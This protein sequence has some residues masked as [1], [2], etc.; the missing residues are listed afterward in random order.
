MYTIS[1]IG[2]L[3]GRLVLNG[4]VQ[5]SLLN[6][7]ELVVRAEDGPNVICTQTTLVQT[8]GSSP[9]SV[10]Y[11]NIAFRKLTFYA[12]P[13]VDLTHTLVTPEPGSTINI[14]S[15]GIDGGTMTHQVTGCSGG[16]VMIDLSGT[17]PQ[18]V[19]IGQNG[20]LSALA[21]CNVIAH[22]DSSVV[23][24][25]ALVID[26]T[27]DSRTLH[28]VY[29]I[30]SLYVKNPAIPDD[31]FYVQFSDVAQVIVSY[32]NGMT[33]EMGASTQNFQTE[34]L[35]MFP[36]SPTS[37]CSVLI[38]ALPNAMFINGTVTVTANTQVSST[39]PFDNIQGMLV[40][41][42]GVG[43]VKSQVNII[44]TSAFGTIPNFYYADNSCLSILNST[45]GV[46]SP[47]STPS[48]WM[49]DLIQQAGFTD[50]CRNC[51][52]RYIGNISMTITTSDGD[53]Y[54]YATTPQAQFNLS[55][56]GGDDNV[57]PLTSIIRHR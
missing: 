57:Y 11:S 1:Q 49:C 4:G 44:L 56:L 20:D 47:T 39:T 46:I 5:H 10:T 30:G 23:Q 32:G 53:D 3:Y 51:Q 41:V 22:G 21:Q 31:F 14:N 33:A 29:E 42:G 55:T 27:S 28:F 34:F 24:T 9:F 25:I 8:G 45:Y 15:E 17:G 12:A 52:V 50:G 13:N 36:V 35:F 18:T 54:F 16:Y 43:A 26:A 37:P 38:D 6:T 48:P 40:V 7:L 19:I 2:K